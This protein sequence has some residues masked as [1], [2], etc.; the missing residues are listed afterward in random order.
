MTFLLNT[1]RVVSEYCSCVCVCV[2][3]WCFGEEMGTTP[4]LCDGAEV[5]SAAGWE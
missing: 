3:M 2:C 5:G 4:G 1:L